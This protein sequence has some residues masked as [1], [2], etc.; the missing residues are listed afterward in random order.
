M[1]D[2]GGR[3]HMVAFRPADDASLEAVALA[4]TRAATHDT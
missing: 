1:S 4:R 2:L 3:D